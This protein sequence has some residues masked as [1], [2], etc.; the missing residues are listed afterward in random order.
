ATIGAAGQEPVSPTD[1]LAAP[2]SPRQEQCTRLARLRDGFVFQQFVASERGVAVA[3]EAQQDLRDLIALTRRASKIYGA[4][5][6]AKEFLQLTQI[7]AGS[8]QALLNVFVPAGT[9][10]NELSRSMKLAG[11]F[12]ATEFAKRAASSVE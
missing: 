9:V 6:F 2:V 5:A 12:A 10:V 11:S 8:L 3:R 7:G 4:S 1:G